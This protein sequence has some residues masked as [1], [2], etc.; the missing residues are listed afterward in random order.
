MHCQAPDL[1]DRAEELRSLG[2][3]VYMV[4]HD[5]IDD[6]DRSLPSWGINERGNDHSLGEKAPEFYTMSYDSIKD[7]YCSLPSWGN[8]EQ[9]NDRSLPS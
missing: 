1:K 6:V 3:E 4:K 9:G 8:N 7:V 2:E 5:S